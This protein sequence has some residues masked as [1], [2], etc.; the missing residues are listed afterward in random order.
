VSA[1]PLER[2][3]RNRWRRLLTHDE[4]RLRWHFGYIDHKRIELAA[5]PTAPHRGSI[6]SASSSA[7][8][9]TTCRTI[10][11]TFSS[12]LP[13]QGRSAMVVVEADW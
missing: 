10:P 11:H 6:C 7:I 13:Q 1:L 2:P 4:H 3:R 9:T 5:L 8:R 12:F